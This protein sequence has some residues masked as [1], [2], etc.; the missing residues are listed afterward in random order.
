MDDKPKS[1]SNVNEKARLLQETGTYL[2]L[3][4]E[5]LAIVS[6]SRSSAQ[7]D[8]LLAA[9]EKMLKNYDNLNKSVAKVVG[10]GSNNG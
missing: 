9:V 6:A 4:R 1:S 8:E 3:I 5:L 7:K 2:E 10:E